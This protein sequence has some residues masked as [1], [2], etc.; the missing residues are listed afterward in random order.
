[1]QLALLALQSLGQWP[2]EAIHDSV[3]AIARQPAYA[4]PVRRSLLGRVFMYAL[5]RLGYLIGLFQGSRD[6][7][8]ATVV[9]VL[10]IGVA[11]A[12]RIFVTRQLDVNARRSGLRSSSGRGVRRDYWAESRELSA[13]GDY[14]AASHALYAAVIEA[15]SRSGAVKF[16]PS[17][18]SG[19]YALELRRGG[20]GSSGEFRAFARRFDR[21]VYGLLPVSAEEFAELSSMARQLTDARVAA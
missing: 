8:I 20:F 16:H 19:D 9:A 11:I 14:V 7:R 13:S 21:V 2:A 6:L 5:E 10:L 15:L 12:G 4:M 1:M 18:T 17:K 3:A